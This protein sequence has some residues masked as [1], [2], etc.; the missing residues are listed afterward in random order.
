ML[1]YHN[2][3]NPVS[4]RAHAAE[5]LCHV[6]IP[7]VVLMFTVAVNLIDPGWGGGGICWIASISRKRKSPE[8][9]NEPTKN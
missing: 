5:L 7:W 2:S 9:R 3:R 8:K 1:S 4:N 6:Y